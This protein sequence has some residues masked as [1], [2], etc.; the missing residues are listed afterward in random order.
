MTKLHVEYET[1]SSGGEALSNEAWSDRS[2]EVTT[3]RPTNIFLDREDKTAW[4]NEDVNSDEDVV[5][6]DSVY[7]VV[8]RYGDGDT[9]GHSTGNYSFWGIYRCIEKAKKLKELI[10]A[11]Y[12]NNSKKI[13][14][15]IKELA[16]RDYVSLY[17]WRGYFNSLESVEIHPMTVI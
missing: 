6:G 4:R 10:R 17:D 9:F 15:Q 2:D 7:L 5:A 14:E 1:S 3:F 11:D 8:V 13:E 12:V 16:T